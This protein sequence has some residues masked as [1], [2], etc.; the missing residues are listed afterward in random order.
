MESEFPGVKFYK[1]NVDENTVS[2]STPH[3][4]NQNAAA[5]Y[6]LVEDGVLH[7]RLGKVCY[8]MQIM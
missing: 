6:F 2:E 5:S 3:L 7:T 1:V 8:T 4:F